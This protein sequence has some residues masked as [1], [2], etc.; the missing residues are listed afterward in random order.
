MQTP[1][2]IESSTTAYIKI[3]AFLSEMFQNFTDAVKKEMPVPSSNTENVMEEKE[4]ETEFNPLNETD[5][6]KLLK[7]NTTLEF[8][9]LR[10]TYIFSVIS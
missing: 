7:G 5:T 9:V 1:F 3:F 2:Q 4:Q 8:L 10:L 6:T